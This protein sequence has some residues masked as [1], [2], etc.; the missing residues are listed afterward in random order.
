MRRRGRRKKRKREKKKRGGGGN[1]EKKKKRG[2]GE[3]KKRGGRGEREVGVIKRE[4]GQRESERQS[5]VCVYPFQFFKYFL[6]SNF[7]PA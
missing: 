7:S 2:R 3:K 4:R 1:R 5:I 6:I